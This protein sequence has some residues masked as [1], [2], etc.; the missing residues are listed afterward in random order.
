[1]VRGSVHETQKTMLDAAA[2]SLCCAER[3]E[4]NEVQRDPHALGAPPDGKSLILP[5]ASLCHVANT[6]WGSRCH[7]ANLDVNRLAEASE[8]P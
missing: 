2:S 4:R 7:L 1:V 6:K 5:A 8:T 3:Y